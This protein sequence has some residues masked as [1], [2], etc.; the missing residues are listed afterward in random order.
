MVHDAQMDYFGK[1]L[2]TASSD[3]LI[4][5]F[6]VFKGK[7]TL[8]ADLS[9][10]SGPVWKVSWAHPKFGSKLVSCGYDGRVIVWDEVGQ[11][12][13]STLISERESSVNS[14]Q[15]G[16]AETNAP[17]LA[18]ACADGYIELFT[19]VTAQWQPTARFFG[20]PNGCNSISW[21]PLVKTGQLVT[22]QQQQQQ[23]QQQPQAALRLVSGGCDS[24]VKVWTCDT[25]NP[26]GWV[27]SKAFSTG[28]NRHKDWVYD[29]AWAPSIGLPTSTIASCSEDKTVVIWS[30]HPNGKWQRTVL[31]GKPFNHKVW[32][33]SWS[34]MGNILAVSHGDNTVTLWK[35]SLD[36]KWQNLSNLMQ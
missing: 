26:A 10:H 36:G 28:Q 25:S 30:E 2:A 3:G 7:Q 35:E 1:R 33:V 34:L 15:W 31:N 6:E 24:C 32:K 19:L 11:S 27:E 4:K 14:V 22:G 13:K 16:P 9:G 5:I 8:L 17:T 21:A 29:V 18:T 20:H 23:H 12:W